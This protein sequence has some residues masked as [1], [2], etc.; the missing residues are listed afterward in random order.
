MPAD[1]VTLGEQRV[2][3]VEEAYE[4]LAAG[5]ELERP[6]ALFVVLDRVLDRAW[7]AAQGRLSVGRRRVCRVA[8]HL[9]D[10]L[11]RATRRLAGD[12]GIGG[13]GRLGPRA[14]PAGR[15]E[16]DRH[17]AAVA[18][19]NLAQREF[20]LA[21]PGDVGRIAEGADHEDAGALLGVGQFAREDR[22]RHAEDRRDRTPAEQRLVACVVGVRGDADAGGQQLGPRGGDDE[23]RVAALDPEGDVVECA[24][25][26]TILDFGLRDGGLEVD[27]P[28]RGRLDAV[29]VPLLPQVAEARLRDVTAA[30]VDRR[31]LLVPVDREPDAAPQRLE[32][33][34]VATGE[35]EAGADEVGAREQ[36]RRRLGVG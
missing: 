10:R 24:A 21:P 17:E 26:R 14:L 6:V 13:V 32:G 12:R 19:Q 15:A 35:F 4:P 28:H 2:L 5:D 8:Q 29:D 31:V 7:L 3:L 18:A 36:A 25:G 11:A 33:L 30:L 20:L 1:L 9:D 22:Y 23:R 27:V 16:L 34:L